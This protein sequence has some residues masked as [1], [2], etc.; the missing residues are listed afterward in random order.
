MPM[1]V[2]QK[3]YGQYSRAWFIPKHNPVHPDRYVIDHLA[4]KIS[5]CRDLISRLS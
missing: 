4:M 2:F 5:E 1:I 3:N